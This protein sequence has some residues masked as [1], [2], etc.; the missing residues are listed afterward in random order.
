[1]SDPIHYRVE[2]VMIP[3]RDVDRAKQFYTETLGFPL[4]G[5]FEIGEGMRFVQVTPPGSSCSIVFGTK[6]TDA[7]PGSYRETYI[8]VSDI[9]AARAELVA[10]GAEVDEIIHFTKD[11]PVPGVDPDRN[12][13]GSVAHFSDPDGNTFMLQ[14]V[15]SRGSAT[16]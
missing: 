13:F 1:M 16:P 5:D 10:R 9:E 15:P 14:E 3:V 11:G 12:D 6:L 4:D 7:A 8:V 2:V